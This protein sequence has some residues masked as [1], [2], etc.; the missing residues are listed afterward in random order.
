MAVRGRGGHAAG[1]VG[2]NAPA[3]ERGVD[4]V[5]V[6][7][8]VVEAFQDDE[9]GAFAGEE[10]LGAFVVDSH[11]AVGE[12]ADLREADEFEGVEADVDAT[13]QGQ[14]GVAV[15]ESVG[16]G[17]DRQERRR[18]RAVDGVA[19]AVQ[20]E[21]VADAAGDGVREC[22]RQ[23]VFVGGWGDRLDDLAGGL[24]QR[25]E[26]LGREILGCGRGS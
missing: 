24:E 4:V 22:A 25:F 3:A 23:G 5:A 17:G 10:A 26:D 11:V 18:T 1:T 9:A 19:A 13:G 12:G 15:A 21:E 8:G 14:V 6:P 2:G 7:A 20:V 16:R